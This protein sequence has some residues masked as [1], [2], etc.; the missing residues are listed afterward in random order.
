MVAVSLKKKQKR[1]Q[2]KR[3][4]KRKKI[5]KITAKP[6]KMRHCRLPSEQPRTA[7]YHVTTEAHS[8]V[9]RCN[10]QRRTSGYKLNGETRSQTQKRRSL[11]EGNE[12]LF[13]AVNQLARQESHLMILATLPAPTVRPPSRIAKRRPSSMA[14]GWISLTDISV[15]SPGMTISVPSGG[16]TTPVT[17]VVRK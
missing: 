16:C 11:P 15:V 7:M 1:K 12:R 10:T 5:K 9:T 2:K 14:T 6:K 3:K 17:S 8:C 13:S 4:K